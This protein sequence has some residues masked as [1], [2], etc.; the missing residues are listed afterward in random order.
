M[1]SFHQKMKLLPVFAFA[2]SQAFSVLEVGKECVGSADG[3]IVTACEGPQEWCNVPADDN[4][5]FK[6]TC[7]C[8]PGWPAPENTKE[9]ATEILAECDET[10]V[11]AADAA[12][13]EKKCVCPKESCGDDYALCDTFCNV[14]PPPASEC[15][16]AED[17]TAKACEGK[18]EVCIVAEDAT[19]GSGMC[20]CLPGYGAEKP[21]QDKIADKCDDKN[22]CGGGAT[23]G[24]DSKCTCSE[25]KDDA[26]AALCGE[27]GSK[28]DTFCNVISS[29]DDNSGGDSGASLSSVFSA[30]LLLISFA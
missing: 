15:I 20:A 17:D 7:E 9:C 1:G 24:T 21:C 16:V 10:N 28:C 29:G 30:A 25:L 14:L 3:T 8:L 5:E 6:G 12:C 19:D 2:S 13:T 4:P 11:C 22:V 27:D 26:G 23:C 18:N